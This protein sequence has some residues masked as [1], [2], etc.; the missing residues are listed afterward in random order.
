MPSLNQAAFIAEAVESVLLHQGETP[1]EL[2]VA[3]GGSSDGTQQMLSAL[4]QRFGADRLRWFSEPDAGPADAV[5]RAFALAR[6]DVIGWLNSD[7]LYTPG[8]VGHGVRLLLTHPDWLLVY[9]EGEHIGPTGSRLGRY[10]TLPPS[11]GIAAFQTGCYICQPTAFLRREA[12]ESIGGLDTSLATAFD[13]EFW[14]RLFRRWPGRVGHTHRMQAKSRL[15]PG[16]ITARQRQRV[17]AEGVTVLARHLGHA[18]PDWL[19]GWRDELLAGF[20]DGSLGGE[21][22][23]RSRLLSL[24]DELAGCFSRDDVSMLRAEF[25]DDMRLTLADAGVAANIGFDAWAPQRLDLLL[26]REPV[27]GAA[28]SLR[29]EAGRA[30]SGPLYLRVA[31]DWGLRFAERVDGPGPFTLVLPCPPSAAGRL[32]RITVTCDRAF[33][34]VGLVPGSTDTR[35]LAWRLLAAEWLAP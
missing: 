5:N 30:L 12:F 23:P 28:L 29:G 26:Q 1:L 33:S 21:P 18:H 20:A 3:D 22:S 13:F 35:R 11:A 34:P 19:R 7:D 2:I 15:H 9:G 6:S 4:V 32:G 25:A 31:A 17:Q 14:L 8:A 10:P 16:G 24:L 27:A